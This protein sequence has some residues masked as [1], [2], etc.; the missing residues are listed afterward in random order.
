MLPLT[1]DVVAPHDPALRRAVL[2]APDVE[3][4]VV[5]QHAEE[6]DEDCEDDVLVSSRDFNLLELVEDELL[7]G[8]PAVPK[9]EVCP[10]PVKMQAVDADFVDEPTEKPNPF[11]KLEQLKKKKAD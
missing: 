5:V 8:L 9:H 3:A 4:V 11:A 7:M 1:L 6:L 10:E 2:L